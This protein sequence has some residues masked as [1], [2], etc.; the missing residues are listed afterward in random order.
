MGEDRRSG[1]PA[2]GSF[3][4]RSDPATLPN[5]R[6]ITGLRRPGRIVNCVA[7]I[8][9]PH[10]A[11]KYFIV[12]AARSEQWTTPF[13]FR[14]ATPFAADRNGAL[15]SQETYIGDSR[16]FVSK[17]VYP[18]TANRP[19]MSGDPTSWEGWSHVRWFVEEVSAGA[20]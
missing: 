9:C 14:S 11:W 4:W 1:D 12:R 6:R 3:A 7:H 15:V 16:K 18:V 13:H 5:Q 10:G 8:R 20:A 19:G 17:H 2:A